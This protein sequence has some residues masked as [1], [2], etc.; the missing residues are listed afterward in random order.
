MLTDTC[1]PAGTADLWSEIR[2]ETNC[3]CSYYSYSYSNYPSPQITPTF[4]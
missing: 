1:S 3:T 4:P 2:H